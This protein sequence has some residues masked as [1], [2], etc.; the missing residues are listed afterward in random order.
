MPLMIDAED[1]AQEI[2][3][4]RHARDAWL[5]VGKQFEKTTGDERR[6]MAE[7]MRK[8]RERYQENC[9]LLA[10]LFL[11]RVTMAEVEQAKF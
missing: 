4:V 5:E 3:N 9:Q 1:L 8:H 7:D 10:E 2:A 6:A 11:S